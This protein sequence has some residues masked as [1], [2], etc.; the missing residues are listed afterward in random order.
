[1]LEK[2]MGTSGAK[3]FQHK[4]EGQQEKDGNGDSIFDFNGLVTTKG[5]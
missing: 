1:M 2:L 5:R 4:E 3:K